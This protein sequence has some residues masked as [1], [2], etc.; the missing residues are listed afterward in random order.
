VISQQANITLLLNANKRVK[1]I[2]IKFLKLIQTL[3]LKMFGVRKT[4][5]QKKESLR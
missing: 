4:L 5:K 3:S 1:Q 2:K